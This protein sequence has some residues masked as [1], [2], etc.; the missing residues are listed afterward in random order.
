M[1]ANT[2]CYYDQSLSLT[3]VNIVDSIRNIHEDKNL[4]THMYYRF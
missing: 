3:L 4:G 2:V 1:M